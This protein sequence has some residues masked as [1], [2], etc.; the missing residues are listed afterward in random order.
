MCSARAAVFPA[1][2]S[3][4]MLFFPCCFRIWNETL[5]LFPILRMRCTTISIV[6]H[7]GYL[8]PVYDNDCSIRGR[9]EM[10]ANYTLKEGHLI[11]CNHP[12]IEID[13]LH[14][15]QGLPFTRM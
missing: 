7:A 13:S 12:D 2:A 15:M 11:L 4:V 9:T 14:Q 10:T 6:E 8:L 1:A 5:H 3:C